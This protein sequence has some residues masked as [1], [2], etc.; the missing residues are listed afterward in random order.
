MYLTII[1]EHRDL[2]Y[3]FLT[4][5]HVYKNEGNL[6]NP[7]LEMDA[8]NTRKLLSHIQLTSCSI[9]FHTHISGREVC[10]FAHPHTSS[11]YY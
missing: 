11:T 8:N 6:E 2:L 1:V 7:T 9:C 5:I 10:L 3:L 4:N